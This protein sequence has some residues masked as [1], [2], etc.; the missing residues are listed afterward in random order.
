LSD[1]QQAVSTP[2]PGYDIHHIVEKDSAKKDGFP[3]WIINGP[4][5]LVR[6]PRFK[7]WEITGWYMTGNEDYGGLSPRDYL[8]G[9]DWDERTRVGLRALIRHGVLK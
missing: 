5:N 6:I 7:H 2:E 9:K 1:L 3:P 8:R 4:E